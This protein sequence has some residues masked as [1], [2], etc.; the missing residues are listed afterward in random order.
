MPFSALKLNGRLLPVQLFANIRQDLA[1]RICKA[2]N[3]KRVE[4]LVF[5]AA[6]PVPFKTV[7]TWPNNS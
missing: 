3:R 2:L 7:E 6:D 1:N 5:P 4:P